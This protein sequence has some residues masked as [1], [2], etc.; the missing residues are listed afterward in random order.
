[1]NSLFLFLPLVICLLTTFGGL[2]CAIV[3]IVGLK[4]AQATQLRQRAQ[5]PQPPLLS[6]AKQRATASSGCWTLFLKG[7]LAFGLGA[8]ALGLLGFIAKLL[9]LA[10]A[11]VLVET[12]NAKLRLFRVPDLL[13]AAFILA[14]LALLSTFLFQ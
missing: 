8:L 3:A 11:V 7:L 1:M 14:T 5:D 2:V 9:V 10:G 12:S 13:S 4:K 6:G